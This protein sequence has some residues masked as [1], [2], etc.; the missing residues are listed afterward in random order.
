M[1]SRYA[2]F[3]WMP[4]LQKREPHLYPFRVL[5]SC[6]E[7]GCRGASAVASQVGEPLL[8]L[9]HYLR[10]PYLRKPLRV[11][12][13]YVSTAVVPFGKPPGGRLHG[14]DPYVPVAASP[15]R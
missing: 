12:R 1:R 2:P 11:Y 4:K 13:V 10:K 3:S 8:S 7:R 5:I 15:R 9:I 14:G 6:L